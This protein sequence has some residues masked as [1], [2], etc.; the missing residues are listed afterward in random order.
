MGIYKAR[1]GL[2]TSIEHWYKHISDLLK[3]ML[4]KFKIQ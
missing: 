4:N 3:E 2:K 1:F